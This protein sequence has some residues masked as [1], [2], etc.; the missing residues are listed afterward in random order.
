MASVRLH[1][2]K[3]SYG[4]FAAVD[5]VS[6]DIAE[7]EFVTLLG[8]S[9]SGKTTCLRIIAG[10]VQPDAGTV[11]IGGDDVTRVPAH[12]RNTG[13]VFQQYA[14]FP[15]L[16]VA[17]NVAFGLRVRRRPRSEMVSETQ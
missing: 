1:A 13:M 3:K 10:F 15:H 4:D 7:G 2:I 17:Q 12:R 9:G 6:L 11:F 16:T 14:L 5:D 8:A